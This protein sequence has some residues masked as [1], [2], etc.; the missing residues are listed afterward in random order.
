LTSIEGL[1]V[2]LASEILSLLKG[3]HDFRNFAKIDPSRKKNTVKEIKKAEI[4]P[5][6]NGTYQIQIASKSFLWQQVRRIIGYLVEVSTGKYSSKHTNNLLESINDVKKPPAASPQYLILENIH[7]EKL[8]FQYDQKSLNSF[9]KI[10]MEHLVYARS[11]NA[12]YSF[13]TDY[14]TDI[15][16]EGG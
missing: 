8:R 15:R 14:I 9:Y 13:I 1:D 3:K 10:I 12:L 6:G 11:H 5:I 16:K 4:I 7:Y 2:T